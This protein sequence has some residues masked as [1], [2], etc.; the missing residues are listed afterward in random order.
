MRKLIT[1]A[2]LIFFFGLALGFVFSQATPASAQGRFTPTPRPQPSST[3]RPEPSSTPREKQPTLV[4]TPTVT[5]TPT[6]TPTPTNTATPT[7]TPTN[8]PTSTPTNTPTNTPTSTPTNTPTPTATPFASNVA[9]NE[10]LPAPENTDWNGDG[11]KNADDS[12]IELYNTSAVDVD[13]TGWH[14]VR[15]TGGDVMTFTLPA[16][17]TIAARSYRTFFHSL[18]KLDLPRA[19][20]EVRLLYPNATVADATRFLALNFDQAYARSEDGGGHWRADCAPTPN[21][22]NCQTIE[23][24]TSS[25]NLLYFKDHI[26]ADPRILGTLDPNV[27]LTNFLLALL[28]ALAMGF[29]GNLLNDSLETHE[30]HVQRLL[31]PVRAVTHRLR[32]AGSRIYGLLRVW[33][34]LFWLG[35]LLRLAALLIIYGLVLAFLDPSFDLVN[36]DAWL[37]ILALALS[38]GLVSL[39]DD[40]AQFI[41]LRLHGSNAVI[42]VHSG[43]LLLVITTTLFSRF[44]GLAPGL[45]I[46]SPA[47]IEEVTDP[48]FEIKSHLLAV[49]SLA[50]VAIGAWALVPLFDTDA[51]FKT[52][53]LLIFAAAVQTLFFEMI[54]L[55]YLHG[56]GVFEFSRIL[57]LALFAVTTTVFLQT[58]LNPD[59]AFV[60]AFK[61]PNMMVL[62]AVVAVFCLFSVAVWFY[63]KRL[64]KA[65]ISRASDE[66]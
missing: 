20:S 29:F 22:R 16:T 11:I 46:G 21:A 38:A 14:L 44:S 63:L 2:I 1:L 39:T 17:T 59:G 30:E 56:R 28:L 10:I 50:V 3:P 42:R 47:G 55:K 24:T 65:E 58:M 35:I 64:E 26:V 25:F 54:P 4:P 9:L 12:W 57:W 13:I 31:A 36:R 51:W 48:N 43:N 37:L 60:S 61:S 53:C 62:A 52:L 32:R 19:N 41:Y 49:G 45:L 15:L 34:P 18:T 7:N 23:T 8:T 40:I 27:L 33:R 5:Q 6:N 66:R